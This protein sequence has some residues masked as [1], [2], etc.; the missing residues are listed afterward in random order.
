MFGG[1]YYDDPSSIVMN[2]DSGYTVLSS[3]QSSPNKSNL[4]LLRLNNNGDTMWTKQY[5]DSLK[6]ESPVSFFIVPDGYLLI[7]T[8]LGSASDGGTWLIK[9]DNKGLIVWSKIFKSRNVHSSIVCKDSTI[10]LTG[11]YEKKLFIMKIAHN[12]DSLFFRSFGDTTLNTFGNSIIETNDSGYAITG[13]CKISKS[14]AYAILYRFDR[15]G[16]TIWTFSTGSASGDCAN[17][18]FQLS[19]NSFIIAGSKVPSTSGNPRPF[20][21][22]ISQ[23][24]KSVWE[25]N[26]IIEPYAQTIQKVCVLPNKNICTIGTKMKGNGS[27]ISLQIYNLN[28]DLIV[29]KDYGNFAGNQTYNYFR[30]FTVT[31]DETLVITACTQPVKSGQTLVF[32]IDYNPDETGIVIDQCRPI[33]IKNPLNV[34]NISE[35]YSLLGQKY[36]SVIGSK[37]PVLLTITD[38]NH[39][40]VKKKLFVR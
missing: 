11:Q 13:Q 31:N 29:S 23:S 40:N 33:V 17:D 12:G 10:V 26:M 22:M 1:N 6:N 39:L 19:D 9:C 2:P 8:I 34:I 30:A 38:V 20:L 14:K 3:Y 25:R 21:Q 32:S 7:A 36:P 18:L 35:M 4:W 27:D 15:S 24:G 28:G 5:G 16:D 37:Y